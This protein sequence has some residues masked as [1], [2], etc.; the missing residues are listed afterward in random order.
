M[1]TVSV[2]IDSIAAG[3]DG[4]GRNEGL[5]VFVPRTA[6]GD[7]VTA[8]ISGRGHFARGALRNVVSES[9]SRIDPP[10]PHYTR[11][12]CGG[13]QLQHMTYQSQL[14]AKQRIIRDSVQRIGKRSVELPAI[15]RSPKEWRYRSKLTLAMRRKGSR[16]IAGLHPYDDPVRVFALADCPITDSRVV[17]A[18]REVMSADAFFPDAAELRGS[19]RLTTG[20]PVFVMMGG[21]SWAARDQFAAS[22]PSVSAVWWQAEVDK[23]RRVLYDRRADKSPGASFAQVNP[24]MAEVLREYVVGCAV[25]YRPGTA[26]DGYSGA[27]QTA[28]ALSDKGVRVSAIELDPDAS[29][30]S[31]SKL[32]APS[33]AVQGKVEDVLDG[34]LPADLVLLNPPRAGVDARVTSI[35]EAH[36]S[37]L[38]AVI[39]VS[40]NPATLARDLSRLPSF[41][42]ESMR[43]FDMFPQTA[44]V[45]TVC[46]LRPRNAEGGS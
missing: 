18:W 6:P 27:G 32:R 5:V 34:L 36:A 22:V 20:G 40:C 10:C 43:A 15:E 3:G 28:T 31:A 33:V 42:I 1:A 4:V 26:I 44:H 13:C 29:N 16:W 23:P 17:A 11:D 9:D 45:E 46:E 39:Y 19:I 12:K 25:A 14:S 35:L 24:E 41:G 7:V 8:Q 21:E 2:A 38:K 30:W 37:S